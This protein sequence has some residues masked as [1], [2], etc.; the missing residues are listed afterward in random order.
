MSRRRIIEELTFP[1]KQIL[2]L[3]LLL[4]APAAF[5]QSG[6]VK[7]TPGTVPRKLVAYGRAMPIALVRLRASDAGVVTGLDILPG[8]QVKADAVLGRLMGPEVAARLAAR[9]STVAGAKADLKA[10]KQVLKSE[11]QKQATHLATEPAVIKA[12]AGVENANAH[13]ATAKA[14]L[15]GIESEVILRAPASGAVAAIAAANG[16]R[17]GSGQTILTILPKHHTWLKAVYY[18]QAAAEIHLGMKGEFRP[19]D[20]SAAVA[21]KVVSILP[22]V[23][24]DGGLPVGMRPTGDNQ[25]LSAGRVGTVILSGTPQRGVIVPTRALILDHGLWWVLVRTPHGDVHKAVT[26]GP[27]HG[28]Q[29]LIERGIKAGAEVVVPNAYLKFHRGVSQHYQPPD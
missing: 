29:T 13:L 27:S 24:P 6:V 19:A 2:W 22:A 17:V 23:E 7:A 12:E 26:L 16:E 3:A 25:H 21:V 18:G 9:N 5:A 15:Q 28:D 10:A 11:Q 4:F 20:G 14:D 8:Q 1:A